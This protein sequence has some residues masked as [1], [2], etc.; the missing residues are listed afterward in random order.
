MVTSVEWTSAIDIDA[1]GRGCAQ[2]QGSASLLDLCDFATP[3]MSRSEISGL[4][5]G[6]GVRVDREEVMDETRR[7][8]SP[9]RVPSGWAPGG[10]FFCGPGLLIT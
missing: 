5:R 6:G 4:I 2:I 7:A 8:S 9:R 3:G 1:V 10:S